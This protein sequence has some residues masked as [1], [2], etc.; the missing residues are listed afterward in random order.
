M[1]HICGGTTT[2][3]TTGAYLGKAPKGVHLS[4][5]M[6]STCMTTAPGLED[7]GELSAKPINFAKLFQ[8]AKSKPRSCTKTFRGKFS[9]SKTW[10]IPPT[11]SRHLPTTMTAQGTWSWSLTFKANGIVKR[12]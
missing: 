1:S 8:C 2:D 12:W 11:T 5:G 3:D 7:P 6:E 9:Y 4:W 10:V